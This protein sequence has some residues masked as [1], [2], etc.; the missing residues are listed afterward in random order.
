MYAFQAPKKSITQKASENLTVQLTFIFLIGAGVIYFIMQDHQDTFWSRMRFLRGSGPQV[1]RS[2]DQNNFSA[3]A[4]ELPEAEIILPE[5]ARFPDPAVSEQAE[6]Q[7]KTG[8]PETKITYL[9]IP[10]AV[11]NKWFED[12]VLTRVETS[13]GITIAYIPQIEKVLEVSK[14]QIKVVKETSFPYTLNQLHTAKLENYPPK[15]TNPQ[16]PNPTRVLANEAPAAPAINA[17]ATIDEEREDTVVGQ[18]EVATNPQTSIPARFEMTPDQT[19][20]MSGFSRTRSTEPA[21][22]SE[23]VVILQ[24]IK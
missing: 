9:E 5:E 3:P 21:A 15:S 8:K 19:F 20:I 22:Q 7:T 17:Y 11:L 4:P 23:L 18:L 14:A 16:T 2:T 13:D 6:T 12:G 10:T 1:S 24:I